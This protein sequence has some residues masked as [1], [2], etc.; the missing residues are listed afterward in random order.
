MDNIELDLALENLGGTIVRDA[1]RNALPNKKTGKL[2]RSFKSRTEIE[3]LGSFSVIIN[4][5]HYGVYLNHKTNYMDKAID[6]NLEKGIDNIVDV[7]A[8]ELVASIIKKEQ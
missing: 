7:L 2:D 3:D 8:N 1:K 6:S 5:Q 4:E